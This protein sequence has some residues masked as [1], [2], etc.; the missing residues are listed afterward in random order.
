VSR[1]SGAVGQ[2]D[3]GT[4]GRRTTQRQDD[5]A[6]ENCQHHHRDEILDQQEQNDAIHDHVHLAVQDRRNTPVKYT[7]ACRIVHSILL[8]FCR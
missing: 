3:A 5:V 1:R 4:V 8:L 7:S 2:Q 6:V